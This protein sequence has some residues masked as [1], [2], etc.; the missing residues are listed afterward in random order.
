M[1]LA[2]RAL[3]TLA[4]VAEALPVEATLGLLYTT[5]ALLLGALADA[6]TDVLRV[7][8]VRLVG[9]FGRAA[10][11]LTEGRS[12]RWARALTEA[13]EALHA[14]ATTTVELLAIVVRWQAAHS[15]AVTM[16]VVDVAVGR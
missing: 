6:G 13:H 7:A 9:G 2:L 8:A 5:A 11:T 16:L 10:T 4:S 15:L 12:R 3:G 1:L 14:L